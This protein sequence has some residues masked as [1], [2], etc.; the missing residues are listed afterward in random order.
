MVIP[1]FMSTIPL[2]INGEA[3]ISSTYT[4][5]NF[6]GTLAGKTFADLETAIDNDMIYCNVHTTQHP[7]GVIRGQVS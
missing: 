4:T 1:L 5:A 6:T 7:A 2:T 3:I